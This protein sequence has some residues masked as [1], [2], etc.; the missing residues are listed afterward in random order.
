MLT[1]T[2]YATV[3]SSELG[4]YGNLKLPN[5]FRKWLFFLQRQ[6]SAFPGFG[7]ELGLG[8]EFEGLG[9]GLFWHLRQNSRKD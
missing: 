7:L 4:L 2:N 1:T 5:T 9:L 8:L 6:N 3:K